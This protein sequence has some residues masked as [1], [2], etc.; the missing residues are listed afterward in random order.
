MQSKQETLQKGIANV[1]SM[2]LT[3]VYNELN[4]LQTHARDFDGLV[5][6][7]V[8]AQAHKSEIEE[9]MLKIEEKEGNHITH[10]TA[11][12]VGSSLVEEED[13]EIVDDANTKGAKV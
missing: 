4:A 3:L 13:H 5:A 1:I 12:I 8:Q 7:M 10:L 6:Q 11:Q 9:K 2:Q